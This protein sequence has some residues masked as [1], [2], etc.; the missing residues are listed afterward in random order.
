M[1]S[2]RQGSW[3]LGPCWVW[4]EVVEETKVQE[5]RCEVA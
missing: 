4:L 2:N 1:K 5:M 3:V